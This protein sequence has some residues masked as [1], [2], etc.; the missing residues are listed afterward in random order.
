MFH[1]CLPR[2]A[3]IRVGGLEFESYHPG[4][5]AARMI[6]HAMRSVFLNLFAH[7]DSIGD[8]GP[9]AHPWA[10]AMGDPD[11]LSA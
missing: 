11:Q 5:N 9:M 2:H 7:A 1:L 8:F 10:E 6:S 4:P 3:I